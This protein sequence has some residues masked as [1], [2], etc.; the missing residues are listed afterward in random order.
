MASATH[1]A[2][3]S[4][5]LEK[6]R[7]GVFF[8]LAGVGVVVVGGMFAAVA[9]RLDPFFRGFFLRITPLSLKDLVVERLD[10]VPL[11]LLSPLP[12]GV[13]RRILVPPLQSINTKRQAEFK[14]QSLGA[15]MVMS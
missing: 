2:T 12:D 8:S 3:H 10:D 5:R 6:R 1:F 14:K 9:V 11:S 4:S 13:I 15:Y 7:G